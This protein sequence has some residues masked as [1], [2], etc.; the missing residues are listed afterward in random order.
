MPK[1]SV[2]LSEREHAEIERRETANESTFSG[3][4]RKI[5]RGESD[6]ITD[7]VEA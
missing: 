3:E 5:L 1:Q 7:E 6:P 2:Y 4:L